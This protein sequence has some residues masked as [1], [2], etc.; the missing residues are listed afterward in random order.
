MEYSVESLSKLANVSV[1]TLHYY[2]EIGLLKPAFRMENGRRY[3]GIEQLLL[4]MDIVFFK[5]L[6]CSLKEIK[7]VLSAKNVNK[8]SLMSAKKQ[9][10]Q[11]EIKR[12][13]K[14]VKTIDE[15]KF[16]F[17]SEENI[18]YKKA[19]KNFEEFQKNTKEYKELFEKEYGKLENEESKK[20][21]KMSIKDQEKYYEN[22]M[23]KVNTKL[24]Y[25]RING[26][27]KKLIK[28]VKDNKKE[29]SKEV[30]NLMKE[31]YEVLN[32]VRPVSKKEWLGIGLSVAED[33][34]TYFCW[35]KIHPQLPEFVAKA[36]KIYGK[37]LSK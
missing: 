14:L 27:M 30:Q 17:S 32:M 15:A 25:K 13:K 21:R 5:S 35:A 16:Y 8:R 23:S 34:D 36:V 2:D 18:D 31:Y 7:S 12:M 3:Y 22:L 10:L 1:R 26:F 9:F 37:N 11:K 19:I 28:A 29:A 24:Y 20:I 33:K 6:G 4:L